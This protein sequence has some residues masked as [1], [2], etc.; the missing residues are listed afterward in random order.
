MEASWRQRASSR[1]C[2]QQQIAPVVDAKL[3][4]ASSSATRKVSLSSLFQHTRFSDFVTRCL[5]TILRI[6]LKTTTG[7]PMARPTDIM[8]EHSQFPLFLLT[9]FLQSFGKNSWDMLVLRTSPIRF[10]GKVLEKAFN[11]P[12]WLSV[13]FCDYPVHWKTLMRCVFSYDR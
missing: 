7:L 2:K 3:P 10:T 4:S 11:S 6:S 1:K 9:V 13:R 8:R 5:T 12:P